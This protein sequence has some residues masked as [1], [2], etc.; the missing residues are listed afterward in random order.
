MFDTLKQHG[1]ITIKALL[2]V[3]IYDVILLNYNDFYAG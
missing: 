3:N 1:N 2:N